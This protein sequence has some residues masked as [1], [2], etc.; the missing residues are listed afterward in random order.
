M[1]LRL[2]A[3]PTN[4]LGKTFTFEHTLI[5]NEL[6]SS[7]TN[8]TAF[9]HLMLRKIKNNPPLDFKTKLIRFVVFKIEYWTR[10]GKTG[11]FQQI[12]LPFLGNPDKLPH[13]VKR[14]KHHLV[15]LYVHYTI[16]ESG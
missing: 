10:I 11:K 6:H 8:F 13:L 12:K 16:V 14:G 3:H 15:D 4:P 9:F 7:K 1:I 5:I 2:I